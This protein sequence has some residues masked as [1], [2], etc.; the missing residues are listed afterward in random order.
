[1]VFLHFPYEIEKITTLKK[2]VYTVH[3]PKKSTML[4][5][6]II[7]QNSYFLRNMPAFFIKKKITQILKY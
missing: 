5:Q 1:M 4:D 6:L 2:Y 3:V 7:W